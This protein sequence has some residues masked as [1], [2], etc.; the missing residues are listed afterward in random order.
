MLVEEINFARYAARRGSLV[1]AGAGVCPQGNPLVGRWPAFV[2]SRNPPKLF[3]K[4]LIIGIFA[5][6]LET[7]TKE[8]YVCASI[9]VENHSM[10]NESKDKHWA[11]CGEIPPI[12]GMHHRPIWIFL[13][14]LSKSIY[15][16]T[17]KMVNYAWG[18]W[19]L[20]KV[21]WRLVGMLTCKSLFKLAYRL[22]QGVSLEIKSSLSH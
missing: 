8:C 15:V 16:A 18:G 14:D 17:R 12:R 9:V 3:V 20:T 19:S 21:R 2:S 22:L 1:D 6:R 13:K 7:R 5:S 4:T 11:C 10:R